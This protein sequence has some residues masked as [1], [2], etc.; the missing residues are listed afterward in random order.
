MPSHDRLQ[1]FSLSWGLHQGQEVRLGDMA[2]PLSDLGPTHGAILVERLR[3]YAGRVWQAPD[4]TLRLQAGAYQ[5]GLTA[6][7]DQAIL[8]EKGEPIDWVNATHQIL[9]KNASLMAQEEDVAI[10]WLLSPGNPGWDPSATTSPTWFVHLAPLPWDRMASLY[11]HG[12]HLV[13]SP[14]QSISPETWSPSIKSRSRLHYYLADKRADP[15]GSVPILLNARGEVTEASIANLAIVDANGDLWTPPT[16]DVLGG[17]SMSHLKTLAQSI[18]HPIREKRLTWNDLLQAKEILL[19][20]STAGLWGASQI[21]GQRID[22]YPGP[23]LLRLSL[24][25]EQQVGAQFRQQP[26]RHS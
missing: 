8:D 15:A 20:G 7:P 12:S 13:P 3:T 10:V 14:V 6:H 17:I 19:A 9:A 22:A 18:G 23:L 21:S 26:A 11:Q 5:L 25:W 2:W 4:H 24:L 1:A 16:S